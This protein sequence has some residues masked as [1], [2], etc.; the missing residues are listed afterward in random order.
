MLAV[1]QQIRTSFRRITFHRTEW[2][3]NNLSQ[4]LSLFLSVINH[5]LSTFFPPAKFNLLKNSNRCL[6]YLTYFLIHSLLR[7]KFRDPRPQNRDT[8]GLKR[9]TGSRAAIKSP[10]ERGRTRM[11]SMTF[12][13]LMS[14]LLT[15]GS[16]VEFRWEAR[17][18]RFHSPF[19]RAPFAGFE[20]VPWRERATTAV[21][22][23]V[24]SFHL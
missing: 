20:R 24:T 4:I 22:N 9:G 17:D 21:V 19:K 7:N 14:R 15:P 3:S 18:E 6:F 13:Q 1:F 16:E 2:L 10:Y 11:A 8:N 5:R 12:G 23:G